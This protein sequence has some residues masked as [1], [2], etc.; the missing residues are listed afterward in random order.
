MENGG[1]MDTLTTPVEE[2]D[3]Q[4]ELIQPKKKKKPPNRKRRK[5]IIRIVWISIL[6]AF[7]VGLA[8]A[9]YLVFLK[10]KPVFAETS[11]VYRGMLE[12]TAAGWGYVRPAESAD[13]AVVQ[14]GTVLES[15]VAEGDKVQEGDLLYVMDSESID[16]VIKELRDAIEKLE[17]E[18]SE[19]LEQQSKNLSQTTITAPFAG[20][21]IDVADSVVNIGDVATTGQKLGTLIDD[22]TMLLTLYYSYAYENDIT[23]GMT[24]QI[25]IPSSMSLIEGQVNKVEKVRRVTP[26]G[27]VLFEVEFAMK[28]PGAL[29]KD[30]MATAVMFN[31]A[32]EEMIPS[33]AGK[34]RNNREQSIAAEVGGKITQYNMHDY[35]SYTAGAVL[36][37]I[38]YIFDDSRLQSNLDEIEKK[39]EQ[40]A[41]EEKK[42]E[43]LKKT[44]PISGTVM[45][46][47]LIVGEKAEPG[48]AV[49]SIAQLDKMVIEAQIDERNI[50]GVAVGQIAMIEQWTSNGTQMFSGEIQSVSFEAKVD[51]S[52]AYFPA[53]ISADNYDGLLLPNMSVN[54]TITTDQRFDIL[55]APVN[56]VKMTPVGTVVFVKADDRPE[57]A[58]DMPPEVPTPEGF[59]AVEVV[60]GMANANGVEIVSGVEDGAEVFTQELDYDPNAGMDG[61]P[62]GAV[63]VR[64]G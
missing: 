43:S 57:N 60:T 11:F 20:K 3:G 45:Y 46:N 61:G 47:K 30:M 50:A 22:S 26:E 4:P 15:L 34:L 21:L 41:E 10:P 52:Y 19:I 38:D 31:A 58:I 35:H 8:I 25:S 1:Y 12:N 6:V 44:S 5:L 48:Q 24:A 40:I 39:L 14:S 49:I 42:Y 2:K 9:I 27:I 13:I 16:K 17:K 28:N 64:V 18:N 33:D 37:K 54:Y 36:C 23:K 59:F 62:N 29:A 53:I 63:S 32:G 55:V 56:A 7:L 51:G